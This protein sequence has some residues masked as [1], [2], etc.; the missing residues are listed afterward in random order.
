MLVDSCFIGTQIVAL[1][2]CERL[3]KENY[4]VGVLLNIHHSLSSA[5][6]YNH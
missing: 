6:A 1:Q 3:H 4:K 2:H 5:F